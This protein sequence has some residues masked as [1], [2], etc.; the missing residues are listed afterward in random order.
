MFQLSR[1]L[2]PPYELPHFGVMEKVFDEEEVDRIRFYE[3]ILDFKDATIVGQENGSADESQT[4]RI[5][6][7]A[8]I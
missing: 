1:T 2:A 5:C 7:N 3:K 4:A 8:S 6:Q